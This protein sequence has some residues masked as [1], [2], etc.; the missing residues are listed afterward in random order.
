MTARSL[1][2]LYVVQVSADCRG[3]FATDACGNSHVGL[4]TEKRNADRR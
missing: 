4:T 3:D 1:G 2:L